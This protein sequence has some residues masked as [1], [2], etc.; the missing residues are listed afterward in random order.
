M[1]SH[2][3]PILYALAGALTA[4]L[5]TT[6]SAF[7]GSGV[8]GVFN[9]GQGNTVN[10]KST[11]TGATA[12]PELLIQN[13]GAGTALSLIGGAGAPAFKVNSATKIGNLN[14]DLLDGLDS[15]ALQKRVTGT[16]AAGQAIRVVNANGSVSCQAVAGGSWSLSGNSGTTGSNF[17]GTTDNKALELKV[18]GQRALRL[19]PNTTSPT[20]VGGFSGNSV[21]PAA[22]GATI[23]GGGASGSPNTITSGNFATIAGGT[24]NTASLGG[25]AVGGGYNNTAS[26]GASAVAGGNGNT[27]S[28]PDSAVAGGSVNTAS[29]EGSAVAGGAGNTASGS[30][31][32]VAGGYFNTASSFGSFAA[33]TEAVAD[34]IGSFVWGDGNWSGGNVYSPATYSFSAHA[35]GGFNFWTNASGPTTGC[36]IAPGGGSINCSS[37]RNVKRDFASV[38][39]EQVLKRLASDPDHDLELQARAG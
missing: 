24:N 29:G 36:W 30:D 20:L 23:A 35:T 33:G 34:D 6:T 32:T 10:Q 25:A 27:A 2:L 11:L 5:L 14:A 8:G 17:L 22:S 31:A 16:C 4:T 18:N 37:D 28:G 13:T 38:N 39:R 19:V 7:A 9:L 1:P 15:A 26:G 21:D 12:D 3:K